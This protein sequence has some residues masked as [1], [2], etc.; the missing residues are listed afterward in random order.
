MADNYL[1]EKYEQFLKRK[2]A[3]HEAK[4]RIWKKRLDAYRKKMDA[5]KSDSEEKWFFLK[6]FQYL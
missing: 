2:N 4:C 1:E 6:I 5:E 3:E